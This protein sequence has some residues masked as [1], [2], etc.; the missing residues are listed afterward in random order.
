MVGLNDAGRKEIQRTLRALRSISKLATSPWL[1]SHLVDKY[2]QGFPEL[3]RY[4]ALK[5]I[6]TEVLEELKQESPGHADLLYGR[7]WE[8]RTVEQ[9]VVGDRPWPGSESSFYNHQ[10]EAILRFALLLW[11][12]EQ[13]CEQN[14]DAQPTQADQPVALSQALGTTDPPLQ[15]GLSELR[16]TVSRWL[17][18][19]PADHESR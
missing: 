9:M 3:T 5:M 16:R 19:S 14:L 6:F 7:F 2:R 11:E 12:K 18:R 15:A 10:K 13:I 4:E 8:G 17:R 1:S